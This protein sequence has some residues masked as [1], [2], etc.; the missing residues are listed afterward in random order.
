MP[1][2]KPS[3]GPRS[4]LILKFD[5]NAHLRDGFHNPPIDGLI[6]TNQFKSNSDHIP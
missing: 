4:C 6:S 1:T 3:I 2:I 5:K